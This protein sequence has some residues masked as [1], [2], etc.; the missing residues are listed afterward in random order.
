MSF[1]NTQDQPNFSVYPSRDRRAPYGSVYNLPSL[2][3]VTSYSGSTLPVFFL[4]AGSLLVKPIAE[5]GV[6]IELPSN[7]SLY[8]FLNGNKYLSNGD[9]Q[10]IT[11]INRGNSTA[12]FTHGDND[13]AY[14]LPGACD[15]LVIQ[16]TITNNS[17]PYFTI[18]PGQVPIA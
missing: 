15:C 11:I 3:D 10:A 8:R 6:T 9:I 18:L 2:L 5:I 1:Y 14:I 4:S 13:P 17:N 12:V 7:A 16:W